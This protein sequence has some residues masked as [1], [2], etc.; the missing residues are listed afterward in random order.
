VWLFY[1]NLLLKNPNSKIAKKPNL[2]FWTF[3]ILDFWEFGSLGRL[4]FCDLMPRPAELL[5]RF[6]RIPGAIH[7]IRIRAGIKDVRGWRWQ[8]L[9]V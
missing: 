5:I 7:L 4:L 8:I 3:G 1:A 2:D 6:P 9:S